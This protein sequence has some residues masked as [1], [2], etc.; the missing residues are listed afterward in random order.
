MLSFGKGNL[1]LADTEALVNTVN[2]VGV[3][4]KGIA[5]Q[6]RERFPQNY[7]FYREAC[8]KG[9]LLPGGLL[10]FRENGLHGSKTIINF[11][12]KDAWFQKSKYEWIE[13]G[14]AALPG[15]LRA[16]N[17]QSIALPPL[18]CGNGG[19]DWKNVK[20]M[21]VR[22]LEDLHDVQVVVFEPDETVLASIQATEKSREIKLTA[23]RAMLLY[24]LFQRE[25]FGEETSLFAA[26]KI[27][28][29][30]QAFGE[31]QLK[32]NFV[33]HYYGPYSNQ[34]DHLMYALNGKYLRGLEQKNMRAFA[35]LHLNY[36]T[37][38]EVKAYCEQYLVASEKKHLDTVLQF[39]NGFFSPLSLEAL[40]SAHSILLEGP[41]LSDEAVFEKIHAWSARKSTL[42]TR[43]QIKAA[44]E[45]LRRFGRNLS[46][47]T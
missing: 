1:L 36:D 31:Q 41:G 23:A 13:A 45:H 10:V 6:F 20:S 43:P 32:L 46:L 38:P 7:K 26:N 14:L 29:F 27:M 47:F 40:A 34:V 9:E 22:H 17:I 30:L 42:F 18:G 19:L 28:Y 35:P 16:N 39:L 8:K 11:A 44:C 37:Y 2:T 33:R 21:I 5:L 12:T 25:A 24:A 3:M 15:V 4:G